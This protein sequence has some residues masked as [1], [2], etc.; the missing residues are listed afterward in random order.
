MSPSL[1]KLC[2]FGLAIGLGKMVL[3]QIHNLNLDQ[4]EKELVIWNATEII[5][6]GQKAIDNCHIKVD[7]SKLRQAKKKIDQVCNNGGEFVIKEML[8]F[9][10]SGLN[11]L[12]HFCKEKE[13]IKSIE[14]AALSFTTL[15]D[16]NLE[17]EETQAMALERYERWAA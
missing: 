4:T 2:I 14:E 9:I 8:I 5:N 12:A 7:K 6:T 13:T 16:P 10:F 1:K 3:S 17:D 15:Y 11:D